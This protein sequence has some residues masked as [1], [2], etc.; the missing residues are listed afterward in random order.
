[1][2]EPSVL[3]GAARGDVGGTEDADHISQTLQ[4]R[5]EDLQGCG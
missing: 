2:S 5:D 1:M 3:E 4:A